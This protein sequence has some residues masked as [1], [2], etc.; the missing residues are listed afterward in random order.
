MMMTSRSKV[1][2]SVIGH[3]LLMLACVATPVAAVAEVSGVTI[4]KRAP[5]GA[6]YEQLTGRIDF[7]LDPKDRRNTPIVDL[8]YAPRGPDGRVRFSADLQVVRPIDPAKRNGVLLFDVP[9]RGRAQPLES[10]LKDGFTYVFV[11]WQADLPPGG[12]RLEAP[13]AQ[14]PA[15]V[16]S[17]PLRIEIM[18]EQRSSEAYLIEQPGRP[19][20]NAPP[21]DPSDPR[22]GLTVRDRFWDPAVPIARERWRFVTDPAGVPKV[23]LD[24]GFEPGRYYRVSY[25]PRNQRIVGVGLAALR[26]AASAFRSRTDLPV[27]GSRAY[28]IGVSQ[29]GRLLRQFLYQGFNVDGQGRPVFDAMIINVAG[30]AMGSFN[31]RSSALAQGDGFVATRFPFSDAVQTDVDGKRDGLLSAY[32]PDQR[33]KIFY[34]NGPAEYWGLGR[35]AALIHTS[36]DGRRDLRLPANER[37]Y[38]A[39]GVQHIPGPFPPTREGPLAGVLVSDGAPKVV[40]QQLNNP[41]PTDL[42]GR[43]LLR[44]LHAWTVSGVAPP[45][46]VYPRL[47]DATLTP[48]AGIAFPLI[49]DVGDPRRIEGPARRAGGVVR[50]LPFLV[51]QV[52]GDGNDRAGIKDPTVAVPLATFTGWN[53]RDP[54][55]GNPQE[56][57]PLLGSWIPFAR[58][59]A[60]REARKDPRPSIE[61]R[62]RD[63]DDYLRRVRAAAAESVRRGFLTAEDVEGVMTRASR[64][65]NFAT[66]SP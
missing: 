33:P 30:A 22:A 19:P 50:P 43:A 7:A 66:A 35:A 58:T 34:V 31:Q 25:H 4:S 15:A 63:R 37:V 8:E 20:V 10:V 52:D 6:A 61:E 57:Y 54:S 9:N 60:E 38:Y 51:P 2:R 21:A 13:D 47:A 53:F 24:G 28:A 48:V 36:L 55:V 29:T 14:L 65:W 41:V 5:F 49:A 12:L 64:Y 17:E 39:S 27:Q 59:R 1:A 11:G 62:Y 26:D 32:R 45:P 44:A 56:I 40:A 42:L 46:S 23:Q 18:V 16:A 3:G